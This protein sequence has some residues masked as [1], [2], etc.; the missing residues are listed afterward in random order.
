MHSHGAPINGFFYQFCDITEV[1]IN[2]SQTLATFD[3]ITEMKVKTNKD[4]SIFLAT[5]SNLSLK[6]EKLKQN[7][8]KMH[9]EMCCKFGKVEPKNCTY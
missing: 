4:L 8:L 7:L 5:Y 9:Q 1:A 2:H 6:M 3:Y